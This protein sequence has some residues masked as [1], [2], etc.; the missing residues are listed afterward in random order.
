MFNRLNLYRRGLQLCSP[1]RPA[2]P[3][4]LQAPVLLAPTNRCF[5]DNVPKRKP[6]NSKNQK[7]I[8]MMLSPHAM[9]ALLMLGTSNAHLLAIPATTAILHYMYRYNHFTKMTFYYDM[10]EQGKNENY[11]AVFDKVKEVLM[12]DKR[13]SL[14]IE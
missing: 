1:Y 8:A 11:L 10:Q 12:T 14:F 4:D 7:Q 3:F 9:I 2:R 13:L 5:S 6:N